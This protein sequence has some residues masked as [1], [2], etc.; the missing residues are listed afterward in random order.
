MGYPVGPHYAESSNIDNA[1]KLKGALMLVI[2]EVDNNVPP[3]S[4]FKFAN[5]LIRA[6]KEFELVYLPGV[7]HSSGGAY[8]NRK[9]INFFRKHLLGQEIENSNLEAR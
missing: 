8:G 7:G 4:T 3:A 5:A 6:G 1:G 9:R 2:G